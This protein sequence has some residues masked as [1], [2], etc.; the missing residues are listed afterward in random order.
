MLH[1]F[2][3]ADFR[4]SKIIENQATCNNES[5]KKEVVLDWGLAGTL[6]TGA[7][8]FLVAAAARG[9]AAA[10]VELPCPM[11]SPSRADSAS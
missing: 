9:A 8:G 1:N 10:P 5:N 2:F 6:A 4:G 3:I 11:G 7:A